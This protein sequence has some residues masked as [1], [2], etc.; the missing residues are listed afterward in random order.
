[1]EYDYSKCINFLWSENK[2]KK[3]IFVFSISAKEW[4]E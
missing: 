2:N 4:L 3:N 1:M